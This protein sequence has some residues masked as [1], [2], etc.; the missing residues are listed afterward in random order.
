[1]VSR[2]SQSDLLGHQGCLGAVD[3][4]P[5]LASQRRVSFAR[6]GVVDPA[7]VTDYEEHGGW[8]GLRRALSLSPADVVA[9]VKPEDKA[10][11]VFERRAEGHV[12]AMV[13]DGVND[14]PALAAAHVGIAVGT[15][16][17]VAVATADIALLRGGIADVVTALRLGRA[18]LRTIRQNLF[19]A[20][21]YNAIGLPLAAGAL[22]PWTGWQLSPVIASATNEPQTASGSASMIVKGVMKLS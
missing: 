15:G 1:M 20:F 2:R 7:S 12:V 8:A 13:G 18:T 6:V 10:R 3:E 21:V 14:A 4:H 17:D 22:H 16:A 11:I 5:W 9:E 19:W